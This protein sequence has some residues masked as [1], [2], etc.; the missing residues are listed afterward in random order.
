MAPLYFANTSRKEE[1]YIEEGEEEEERAH[2]N[3]EIKPKERRSRTV[4]GG[5][6]MDLK[7]KL[8]AF[9]IILW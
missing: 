9:D 3:F 5:R 7:R 2:K 1:L 6:R 4:G 8:V